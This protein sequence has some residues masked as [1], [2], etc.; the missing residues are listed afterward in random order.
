MNAGPM[1]S[2]K[3]FPIT[4]GPSLGSGAH[5]RAWQTLPQGLR[6]VGRLEAA[7]ALCFSGEAAQSQILA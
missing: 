6:A 5:I 4:G 1:F 2:R 7:K 3:G